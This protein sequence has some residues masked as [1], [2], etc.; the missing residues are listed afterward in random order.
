MYTNEQLNA[1]YSSLVGFEFEFFS[2][3]ELNK[4]KESLKDILNKK[5]RI[6]EKAHSDFKPTEDVFKLEPDNSGGSGMIELVTGPLGF[7]EAKIVLA[8]TLKW[9]KENGYTNDRCSIHI[10]LA[11][12]LKKIGKGFSML[13]LDVLKFILNFDE[14][15]IYKLFPNRENSIYARSIKFIIPN[16]PLSL[17]PI[18]S[19]DGII[20][21]IYEVPSEKYF[22]V[23]FSKQ[24]KGYLEFRYLGGENYEDRYD[25]ILK[26]ME[27]FIISLYDTIANPRYTKEDVNK[28]KDILNKNKKAIFSYRSYENF[29]KS[30]PSIKLMVDLKTTP[31]LINMY[32]GRMRGELFN[33]VTRSDLKEG[34]INYDTDIGKLQI[35]DTDLSK[36]YDIRNIDIVDSKIRGKIVDCDIFDCEVNQSSLITCNVFGTSELDQCKLED[37]Y[38]SRNAVVKNSYI[39][40]NMGIFS[41]IMEG[42]IFRKGR[43]TKFAQFDDNA[44]IIEMTKI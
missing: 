17:L 13:R 18:E 20:S 39:M 35:K 2:N 19:I 33:L 9:I 1:I 28:L 27:H 37:S 6:E 42:G 3:Y 24:E 30:Y 8:R 32:Y 7:S 26:L 4:T 11:F 21:N 43:V 31:E 25:S 36:C 10:N 22:G 41:G 38:V 40:G 12:N 15:L 29:K 23:N 16:N 5:I 14:D 34:L 44:E